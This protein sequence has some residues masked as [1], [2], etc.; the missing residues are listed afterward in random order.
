MVSSLSSALAAL[1]RRSSYVVYDTGT[2]AA[3]I[4]DG[5]SDR[6]YSIP[7][8]DLLALFERAWITR[9]ESH[10]GEHFYR[11]TEAGRNAARD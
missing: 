7:T 4:Y 11:L 9:Y 2:K 5:T 1:D 10:D 8:E 6:G 3:T